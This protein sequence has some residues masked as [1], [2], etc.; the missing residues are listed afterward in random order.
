M[1][2]SIHFLLRLL[3]R[4]GKYHI[5]DEWSIGRACYDN[6]SES[7]FDR[8]S[9][10]PG[11]ERNTCLTSRQLCKWHLT[12]YWQGLNTTG[13]LKAIS[14]EKS[15]SR[16]GVHS[17]LWNEFVIILL[18]IKKF[19]S[20]QDSDGKNNP[21]VESFSASPPCLD[22]FF[23]SV[24]LGIIRQAAADESLSPSLLLIYVL[25]PELLLHL[26]FR[27]ASPL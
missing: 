1:H 22:A 5:C 3:R 7:D 2:K 10:L 17:S 26:Y 23:S 19:H 8:Y 16:E 14:S 21:Q 20:V 9:D 27:S 12:C 6:T 24:S 13:G 18:Y 4:P 25:R 11:I 15:H